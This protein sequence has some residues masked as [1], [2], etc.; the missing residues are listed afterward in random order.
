MPYGQKTVPNREFTSL[1]DTNLEVLHYLV[2]ILL[3][4]ERCF[5]ML[6]R[7][8]NCLFQESWFKLA[9]WKVNL[10]HLKFKEA[11][12]NFEKYGKKF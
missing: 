9:L 10:L 11:L 4:L 12:D 3:H 1:S 8:V 7:V 6:S 2:S 5:Q